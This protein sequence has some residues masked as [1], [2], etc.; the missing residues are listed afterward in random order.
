MVGHVFPLVDEQEV[1]PK[2]EVEWDA[3]GLAI[4]RDLFTS[5]GDIQ[6]LRVSELILS[7]NN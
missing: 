7:Y 3:S 1:I 6:E 5:E 4:P 2:E